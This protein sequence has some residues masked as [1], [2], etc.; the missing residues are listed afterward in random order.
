MNKQELN[1]YLKNKQQKQKSEWQKQIAIHGSCT[2]LTTKDYEKNS[3]IIFAGKKSYKTKI[4]NNTI[5][6]TIY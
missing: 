5:W 2:P 3:E 6:K 4:V 1:Q